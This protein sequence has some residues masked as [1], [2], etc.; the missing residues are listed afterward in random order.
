MPKERPPRFAD[1]RA[2]A[3]AGGSVAK[4]LEHSSCALAAE[5]QQGVGTVRS[6]GP[7]EE[8]HVEDAPFGA[9]VPDQ[10]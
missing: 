5:V 9:S 3:G 7:P 2:H 8:G 4:F 10:V 1:S 6:A